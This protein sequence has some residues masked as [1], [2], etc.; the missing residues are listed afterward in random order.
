[1]KGSKK[2]SENCL[3]IADKRRNVAS[4]YL[5]LV[6]IIALMWLVPISF[7]NNIKSAFAYAQIPIYAASVQLENLRSAFFK[8]TL[9][10]R[11]LITFCENLMRENVALQLKVATLPEN[12]S[13]IAKSE[14]EYRIGN[15][16]VK[17]ARV[18]RRDIASWTNEL[19]VDVGTNHGVAEGMGVISQNYVVGRIKS[20]HAKTSV[21]ELISSPQFRMVVHA[22]EDG[23]RFPIVFSGNGHNFFSQATGIATNIPTEIVSDGEPISFVTSELSGAFPKNISVGFI[24][25]PGEHGGRFFSSDVILNNDLLSK[26]YQVAILIN[27]GD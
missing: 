6:F 14:Q 13:S 26:L 18:I 15:F 17:P 11:D 27:L 20:V 8:G 19:I 9:A 1:M 5:P 7:Q 22:R 24:K 21:V 25:S 16:M 4:Y 2:F 10:K 12:I 23:S 3:P